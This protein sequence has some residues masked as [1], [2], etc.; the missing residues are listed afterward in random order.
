MLS[1]SHSAKRSVHDI[2][3]DHPAFGRRPLAFGATSATAWCPFR[4]PA[5]RSVSHRRPTR[6]VDKLMEKLNRL[7]GLTKAVSVE[8]GFSRS[9]QL[10]DLESAAVLFSRRPVRP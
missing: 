9:V 6:Q 7:V 10:T 5:G 2:E 8:Y 3:D 1:P 4:A